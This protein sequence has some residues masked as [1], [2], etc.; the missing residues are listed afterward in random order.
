MT[1]FEKKPGAP[2][3]LIT[4]S[5]GGLT[6]TI[7]D[8]GTID[9]PDASKASLL[10]SSDVLRATGGTSTYVPPVS[11]QD[12]R[13]V[14]NSDADIGSVIRLTDRGYEPVAE[15]AYLAFYFGGDD[16]PNGP[17]LRLAV[18]ADATTFQP[19]GKTVL[20]SRDQD[21]IYSNGKYWCAYTK[22]PGFGTSDPTFGLS[23]ST[24]LVNWTT[25]TSISCAGA[26]GASTTYRAWG[27]VWY[28]DTTTWRIFIA[29]TATD[30]DTGNFQIFELH[31]TNAAM[32]TWSAPSLITITGKASVFDFIP[33][34]LADGTY[35]ALYKNNPA[36]TIERAT[37]TSLLGPYT[38]THTGDWAGWGAAI[39][40]SGA[41]SIEGSH[42][43]QLPNGAYRHWFDNY[44]P[45]GHG[46][47][48]HA[49]E[50]YS[51]STNADLTAW[52]TPVISETGRHTRVRKMPINL[53]AFKMAS[54]P[55]HCE[56][57]FTGTLN[58]A[59]AD[60]A[61]PI[62]WNKV[63][64]DTAGMFKASGTSTE[65][66]KIIIRD[67]GVYTF[68]TNVVFLNA[69]SGDRFL[70]AQINDDWAQSATNKVKGGTDVAV[71]VTSPPRYLRRGDYIK[72]YPG[73][74][75]GGTLAAGGFPPPRVSVTRL[76]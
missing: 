3:G 12:L 68:T 29:C 43:M 53:A 37:A 20:Y 41:L 69:A 40:A 23:S 24:D 42:L 6:Y 10:A 38:P 56:L 13:I 26:F 76:A 19:M 9:E 61:T 52:T 21:I 50:Y 71:T 46:D 65:R 74:D 4:I 70:G 15:S 62:S 64:R 32:T 45:P 2:T 1:T 44:R 34:K 72:I 66:Q 16:D 14:Q 47:F 5:F 54:T 55:P 22:A 11:L 67:P 75:S 7:N 51:D 36:E 57:E 49:T 35:V 33:V 31:P 59:N 58:M 63:I 27:P 60:Y 18:S 48:D 73:Q 17:N 30:S 39:G 25:V 28:K 8:G